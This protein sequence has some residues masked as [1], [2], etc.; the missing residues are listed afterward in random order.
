MNVIARTEG[1]ELPEGC[2][3]VAYDRSGQT[4]GVAQPDADGLFFLTVADTQDGSV[5]FY[6]EQDEEIIAATTLKI[7]YQADGVMGTLEEPTVISF[8]RAEGLAGSGWYDIS[9]RKLQ[10]KPTRR[11]VYIH[12]GK[13]ETIK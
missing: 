6:I 13:K 12:N 8:E 10:G 11:G 1:V 9:G 5:G 4:C 3:L 7:P 2:R